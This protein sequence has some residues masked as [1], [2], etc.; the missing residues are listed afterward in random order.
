MPRPLLFSSSI[1]EMILSAD[2]RDFQACI[3]RPPGAGLP[4][5]AVVLI[6]RA[7]DREADELSLRLA[8]R[9]V[10][11]V[12]FDSDRV[13][14]ASFQWDVPSGVCTFDG[15]S[16]IPSVC[17][18][19]SFYRSSIAATGDA[20]ADA[21]VT[22][23]WA[24]LVA[25]LTED[26]RTDTVNAD[27]DMS[28]PGVLAQ[29][30]AA[31]RA[32]LRVPASIVTTDLADGARSLPGDGDVVVKTLG[33]HFVEVV[34]GRLVAVLPRR[35]ARPDLAD[36]PLEP[37]PVLVQEFIASTRELRIYGVADQLVA[38]EVAKASPESPWTEPD[39]VAIREAPVPAHLRRPLRALMSRLRLDVG[40]FDVLETL[41][42][43]V[44]LEVNPTG[45]WLTFESRAG[46]TT[47]TDAVVDL[48]AG[49]Y[50]N[51]RTAS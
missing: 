44:F 12:R 5:K 37:A 50:A 3:G 46:V 27:A 40:A 10:P 49:R 30:A 8:A 24:A 15:S 43:P 14:R 19:R 13:G 35:V 16:F 22:D 6:T 2:S 42:G 7:G 45:D 1:H 31:V 18:V 33:D 36:R 28:R 23:N 38:F 48:L 39:S 47:V 34:P 11:V 26:P 51:P 17:W 25:A 32:G 29:L 21:Y 20:A 9:N 4:A 41:D